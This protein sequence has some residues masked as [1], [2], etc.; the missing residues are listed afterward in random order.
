MSAR[1]FLSTLLVLAVSVG[2]AAQAPVTRAPEAL[3]LAV[4]VQEHGRTV[5]RPKVVGFEGRNITVERR[6]PDAPNADYRLVLVPREEGQGYGVKLDLQLPSG[7]RLGHV[8]LLHGE[9]RRVTL[10]EDIELKVMLMR[11]DS[12]EFKAL[13]QRAPKTRKPAI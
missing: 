5:A 13:V 6:Q 12:P 11:V 7:R 2:C 8:G 9:E 1:F 3:Y 10:D 4:E